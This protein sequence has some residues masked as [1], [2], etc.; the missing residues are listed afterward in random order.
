MSRTENIVEPATERGK[1][2]REALVEAAER[3]FL[4]QGYAATSV[5]Q[6]IAAAGG[7]RGQLYDW[8][9]GKEGLFETVAQRVCADILQQFER[10]EVDD[11]PP[12]A[13]LAEFGAAFLRT[14]LDPR[15]VALYRLTLAESGRVPAL[16]A[17]FLRSAPEIV[18]ER[19]RAYLERMQAAGR[20]HV[21]DTG[22]AAQTFMQMIGGDALMRAA[23]AVETLS[24][25]DEI[26]RHVEIVV[27][28]FLSGC[29]RR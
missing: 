1:R 27:D 25:D 8:F 24:T 29:Q 21:F 23:L 18:Y 26:A 2:R 6:V 7:S 16:G 20:V 5:E 28:L 19:A 12:H 11:R 15:H 9:G 14:L 3:L 17:L 4:E 13:A 22:H 10:L